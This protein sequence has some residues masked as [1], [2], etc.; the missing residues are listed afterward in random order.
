MSPY[1]FSVHLLVVRGG[2]VTLLSGIFFFLLLRPT[3][4]FSK[5]YVPQISDRKATTDRP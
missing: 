2:F 4:M 5:R 3:D 1:F